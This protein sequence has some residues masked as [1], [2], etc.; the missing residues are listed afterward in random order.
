[1]NLKLFALFAFVLPLAIACQQG[2]DNKEEPESQEQVPEQSQQAPQQNQQV[3]RTNQPAME[4]K[5]VSDEELQRFMT[6]SQEVQAFSQQ[7]Q[8]QMIATVEK[9]GLD[10][11]RFS[12]IRQ[13]QQ[14]PGN[15][16]NATAEEMQKFQTAS[17][18]VQKIQSQ[19]QQ[20][21]V[22]KISEA[23]IS[24]KRYQEISMMVQS[25][26]ELQQKF[27]SMQQGQK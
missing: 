20:Q 27:Q 9:Q 24:E 6:A 26:P 16:S 17:Q 22:E 21:M 4:V 13:S 7:I 19:A 8:Q 5:D 10:V 2:S 25:N 23:G 1:M 12:E 18:E 14:N 15:E 3:P 11:Q